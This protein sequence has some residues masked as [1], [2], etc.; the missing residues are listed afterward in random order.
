MAVTRIH[1]DP[2]VTKPYTE[3]NGR[4]STPSAG[5]SMTELRAGDVRLT[6]GGE[7][8]FVSIDDRDAPEW[9][10]LALGPG[11]RQRGRRP[12]AA[13]ARP[14][15]AGRAAALRTGQVVSR[16]IAAALGLRLLL[17]ARRRPGLA[18]I[19]AWSRTTSATTAAA[20]PTPSASSRRWRGG[21]ASIPRCAI[22]GYEDVWYYLWRERRLPV[23][24]DPLT[25]R[26]DDP[27]ERRRLAQVFEQ[28]L[29]KV[30]GYALPLQPGSRADF[31]RWVSGRWFFRREHMF[32]IPGDSP[33]GFRLPLDSLPWIAAED[34]E[35]LD[36]F[37]PLA[38]RGPLP[39]RRGPALCRGGPGRADKR[40]R[41]WNKTEQTAYAWTGRPPDRV[42]HRP[43]RRA[44][45]RAACT[46]SC[47]RSGSWRS[48]S[49]WSPPSKTRPPSWACRCCSKATSRRTIRGCNTSR[50]RPTPA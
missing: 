30:V 25:N 47:R 46:S 19:P 6:M 8:T 31:G 28:G 27:E 34:R 12:A 41:K 43:V 4:P 33:M 38:P 10:T 49:N 35:V 24:V 13:A 36:A 26:L 16:R 3:S 39:P 45:R 2:R 50:S 18:A 17:A 1:E 37:D 48:I 29:G 20:R 14:L 15:R 5:A 42:A 22:P 11:K 32:L 9:N 7:P 21:S 44:A 23:N 40:P